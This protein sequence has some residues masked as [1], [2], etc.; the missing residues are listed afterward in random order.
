MGSMLESWSTFTRY[1]LVSVVL[2]LAWFGLVLGTPRLDGPD[3]LGALFGL[4]LYVLLI[5]L[6]YRRLRDAALAGGWI[7]LMIIGFNVGP[8]WNG[9]HL[10]NLINLVPVV[11]AWVTPP[12]SGA[13][14]RTV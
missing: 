4:L 12:N 7:T 10:G 14:P 11:L 1:R 2:L 13:N 5:V 6:T 3:W 9:F 8:S